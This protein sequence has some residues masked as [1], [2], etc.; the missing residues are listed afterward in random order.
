MVSSEDL[1]SLCHLCEFWGGKRPGESWTPVQCKTDFYGVFYLISSLRGSKIWGNIFPL[2]AYE[3]TT[4][5]TTELT[6]SHLANNTIKFLDW[7][8]KI[9]S[10]NFENCKCCCDICKLASFMRHNW[11]H[12]LEKDYI[13]LGG[14]LLLLVLSPQ[15]GMLL[16]CPLCSK[17]SKQGSDR[18]HPGSW[19]SCSSL[20]PTFPLSL[21]D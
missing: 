11:S 13:S 2:R 7:E 9:C 19:G 12:G 3:H 14:N 4:Y 21:L 17:Q 10:F 20:S 18:H 15:N 6:E 8:K 5:Q 16:Q 1:V